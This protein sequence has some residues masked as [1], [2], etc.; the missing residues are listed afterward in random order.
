MS[1]GL[2]IRLAIAL[3][4]AVVVG[5]VL[6]GGSD[7]RPLPRAAACPIFPASSHWNTPVDKLP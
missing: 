2:G 7:G 3:L 1:A 6:A 5:V 4:G